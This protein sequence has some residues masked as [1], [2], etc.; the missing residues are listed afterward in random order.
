MIDS[1]LRFLSI[2]DFLKWPKLVYTLEKSGQ[3]LPVTRVELPTYYLI[4]IL[5]GIVLIA[6]GI[7][8]IFHHEDNEH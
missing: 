8:E 1:V 3:T 2:L 7:V 4:F 5:L 6:W